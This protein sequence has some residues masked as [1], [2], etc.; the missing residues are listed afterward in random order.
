MT[1][2]KRTSAAL[3]RLRFD[4]G[5]LAL[6]L[7]ATV[8][9]RGADA[10]HRVER[11]TDE[12]TLDRWCAGVGIDLAAGVD[13]G[14][15]LSELHDLREAAWTVLSA[16]VRAQPAP[17]DTMRR[18]EAWADA[19]TPEPRLVNGPDGPVAL[20]PAHDAAAVCARVARDVLHLLTAPGGRERLRECGSDDCRMVYLVQPGAR[21][22]RW[23]SMSQCGNRAKAAAHRAR[24][25]RGADAA[26]GTTATA[27]ARTR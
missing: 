18:I 17:D 12:G 27:P 20:V 26:P 7:V 14:R 11:L 3:R 13:R 8:G 5:S 16:A 19:R 9:R 4:G 1:P 24:L 10:A 21:E 2:E 25:S 23:C 22:R 15:L 6:D